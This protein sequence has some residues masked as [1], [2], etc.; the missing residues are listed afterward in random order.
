M[1]LIIKIRQP[2]AVC[3]A[4]LRRGCSGQDGRAPRLPAAAAAPLER[5]PAAPSSLCC[6][7]LRFGL[8][9]AGLRGR[10]EDAAE[11]PPLIRT[12]DLALVMQALRK[13]PGSQGKD[14]GQLRGTKGAVLGPGRA[15]A[16]C[17]SR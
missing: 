1:T 4:F 8:A 12:P 16:K 3:R 5:P 7:S 17:K 11:V 2:T 10:Q 9:A 14:K 13:H 6:W 15:A